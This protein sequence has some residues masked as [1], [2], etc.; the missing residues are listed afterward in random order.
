MT[1]PLYCSFCGVS[2]AER[3]FMM[4]GPAVSICGDCITVAV[5]MMANGTGLTIEGRQA[6]REMLIDSGEP[7]LEGGDGSEARRAISR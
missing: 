7:P 6:G 2:R 4:N 3:R 1:E 5:G